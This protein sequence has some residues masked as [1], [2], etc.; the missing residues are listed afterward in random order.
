MATMVKDQRP[1][2]YFVD[3][4]VSGSRVPAEEGKLLIFAS[5]PED[6]RPRVAPVFDALAQ[7]TL[8]SARRPRFPHEAGEQRPARF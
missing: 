1:D 5:S 8:C 2:T 4:P 6:A 7:R 3:A